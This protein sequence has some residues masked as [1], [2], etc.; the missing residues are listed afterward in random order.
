MDGAVA[1]DRVAQRSSVLVTLEF[2]VA[3]RAEAVLGGVDDA[4]MELQ[5]L[6]GLA[7]SA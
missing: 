3:V 7:L 5:G 2:A 6:D 4:A 1:L